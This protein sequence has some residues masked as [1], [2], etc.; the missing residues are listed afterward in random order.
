MM[1]MTTS[2]D[3][4]L[5]VFMINFD[6]KRLNLEFDKSDNIIRKISLINKSTV[7]SQEDASWF[8]I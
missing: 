1:L 7:I 3:S 6:P 2:L 5:K 8:V 4:T